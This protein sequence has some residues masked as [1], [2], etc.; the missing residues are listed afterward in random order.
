M[1]P[2]LLLILAACAADGSQPADPPSAP[3]G[4]TTRTP[5][6]EAPGPGA[7]TE[8]EAHTIDVVRAAAAATVFVSLAPAVVVRFSM[9]ALEVPAGDATGSV[10]DTQGQ[11]VTTFHVAANGR[12][13]TGSLF[14]PTTWP[15]TVV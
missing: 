13:L 12:S 10:W 9:P 7:R 15:A 3:D 6:V 5:L 4:S 2:L 14:D 11:I 8:D 1:R